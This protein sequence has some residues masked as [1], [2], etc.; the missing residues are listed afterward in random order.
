MFPPVAAVLLAE[1]STRTVAADLILS[2]RTVTATEALD[3]GLVNHVTPRSLFTVRL[4]D[5]V[6]TYFLSKSASSLRYA[7]A[8][9]K[10]HVRKRYAEEIGAAEALYLK[11]LMATHDA[12]EGARAFLEKRAPD[13]QDR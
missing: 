4:H 2:G 8:A 7:N 6:V 11:Q 3:L 9:L 12:V 1:K 10:I 13:W 5:F